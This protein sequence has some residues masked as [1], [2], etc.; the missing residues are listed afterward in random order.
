MLAQINGPNRRGGVM[1][2]RGRDQHH[3]QLSMA[4]V[5]HLA[6]VVEDLRFGLI[7]DLSLHCLCDGVLV[8]IDDGHQIRLTGEGE[9]AP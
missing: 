8:H 4:L 6:I 9:A 1:M 3:V 5:Q 2:I 7:L